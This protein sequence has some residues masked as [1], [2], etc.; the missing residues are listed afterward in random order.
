MKWRYSVSYNKNEIKDECE[1]RHWKILIKSGTQMKE[2]YKLIMV[3]W[4]EKYS[5]CQ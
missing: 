1:T 2:A 3:T 4:T 5:K